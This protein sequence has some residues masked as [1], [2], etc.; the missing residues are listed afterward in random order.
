MRMKNLAQKMA[1]VEEMKSACSCYGRDEL[2]QAFFHLERAHI[3]GQ[4]YVIPHTRS[5]WWML[6]VGWKRR[7]AHEIRG[8]IVRIIFALILS[9]IW[10]PLG[11]TGGANVHPLKP[12]WMP[13]DLHRV[14]QGDEEGHG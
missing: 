1:F 2:D 4:S 8:Q 14:M 7:D 13:N 5:H 6:K 3:L 9:R 12:M 10:V 11:N